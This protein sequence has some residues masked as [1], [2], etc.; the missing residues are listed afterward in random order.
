M[1]LP[2]FDLARLANQRVLL[3]TDLNVPLHVADHG[4]GMVISN[5]A[6]IEAALPTI[7]QCM[8]AGASVI[9]ASHLGRPREGEFDPAYS[10]QPVAECLSEL[11]ATKVL[12]VRD[13]RNIA[14]QRLQASEVIL[15]E[16]VRFN[17]GEK[18]NCAQLAQ[19]YAALAEVFVM[20]AFA[21]SH[22]AH[23]STVAIVEHM[24]LSLIHI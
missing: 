19:A 23:A 2:E 24:D 4:Q 17:V 7:K 10:L 6:R 12:C 18:S 1:A 21:T 22:R 11:L 9:I 14:E 8:Q 20:D 13:W 15:L 5:T 3:R 16:N